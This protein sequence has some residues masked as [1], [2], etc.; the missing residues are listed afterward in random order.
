MALPWFQKH[1]VLDARSLLGMSADL[2]THGTS[3]GGSLVLQNKP[4]AA[5]GRPAGPCPPAC[6]IASPLPTATTAPGA[7]FPFSISVAHGLQLHS[8]TTRPQIKENCSLYTNKYCSEKCCSLGAAWSIGTSSHRSRLGPGVCKGKGAAFSPSFSKCLQG[9]YTSA[10]QPKPTFSQCHP[11][12]SLV[13]S[14]HS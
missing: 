10:G 9:S 13:P 5:W 11:A 4:G 14:K 12:Q 6:R 1:K 8:C 7:R 3:P 2:P